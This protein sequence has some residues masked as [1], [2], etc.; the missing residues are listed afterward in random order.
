[1]FQWEHTWQA[2]SKSEHN[3]D[4]WKDLT[5]HIGVSQQPHSARWTPHPQQGGALLVQSLVLHRIGFFYR[6][7]RF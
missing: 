3:E 2:M 6:R 4:M 5:K 1:M 7:Q